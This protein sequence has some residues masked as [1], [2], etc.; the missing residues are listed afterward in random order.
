MERAELEHD[1]KMIDLAMKE[2][3]AEVYRQKILAGFDEERKYNEGYCEV[4]NIAQE[5]R[6]AAHARLALAD[7]LADAAVKFME[8]QDNILLFDEALAAYRKG[9]Q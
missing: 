8:S 2:E 6:D 7:A 4:Y 1:L 3:E 5:Q 9:G